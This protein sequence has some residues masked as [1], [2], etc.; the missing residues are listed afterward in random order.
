MKILAATS[1]TILLE[2]NRNSGYSWSTRFPPPPPPPSA[3]EP[4]QH[5]QLKY[6]LITLKTTIGRLSQNRNQM[7]YAPS[8]G[9]WNKHVHL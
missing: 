8:M 6:N 9:Q 5:Q 2:H 4:L 3:G 1:N 7:V